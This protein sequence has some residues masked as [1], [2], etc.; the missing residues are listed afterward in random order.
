M[1]SLDV[2]LPYRAMSYCPV[3]GYEYFYKLDLVK[4][5][6]QKKSFLLRTGH[7]LC[8]LL[9]NIDWFT[10]SWK[11]NTDYPLSNCWLVSLNRL[12][13]YATKYSQVS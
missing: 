4:L 6:S 10:I 12:P 1:Y 2:F 7:N 11:I 8:Q 9:K 3:A 5:F 13:I